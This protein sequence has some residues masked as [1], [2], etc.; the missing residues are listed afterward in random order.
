MDCPI[1][2]QFA[3]LFF[4]C[5]YTISNNICFVRAKTLAKLEV[6]SNKTPQLKLELNRIQFNSIMVV[7]VDLLTSTKWFVLNA[8]YIWM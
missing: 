1:F 6:Y 4:V 5:L 2:K 3:L 7:S 8:L